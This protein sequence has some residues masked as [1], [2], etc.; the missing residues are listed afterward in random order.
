MKLEG[1]NMLFG[2]YNSVLQ[3]PGGGI[4]HSGKR[5][6]RTWPMQNKQVLQLLEINKYEG[7]KMKEG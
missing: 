4:N 1:E 2:R 6:L 3:L 5:N 7:E